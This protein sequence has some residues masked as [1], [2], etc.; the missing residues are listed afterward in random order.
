MK[1]KRW[2]AIFNIDGKFGRRGYQEDWVSLTKDFPWGNPQQN[3]ESMK[4][5]IRTIF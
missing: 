3:F 1:T 5:G 4:L 2:N